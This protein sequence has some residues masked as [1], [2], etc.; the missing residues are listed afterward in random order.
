MARFSGDAKRNAVAMPSASP[1]WSASTWTRIT[2]S[3]PSEGEGSGSA[4]DVNSSATGSARTSSESA[5]VCMAGRAGVVW[6]PTERG[7]VRRGAP[8]GG[9]QPGAPTR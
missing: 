1:V 2:A 8:S 3:G 7:K 5:R 4:A 9:A 6:V